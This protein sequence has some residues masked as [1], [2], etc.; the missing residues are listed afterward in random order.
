MAARGRSS[1]PRRRFKR[2][3]E[4]DT[5]P[6]LER[7]SYQPEEVNRN[8]YHNDN[9]NDNDDYNDNDNLPKYCMIYGDPPHTSEETI[10]QTYMTCREEVDC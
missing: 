3:L 7:V 9:D 10:V 2:E 5:Q 6:V 8:F 1:L 4:S